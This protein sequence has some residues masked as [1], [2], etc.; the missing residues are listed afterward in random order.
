MSEEKHLK[1]SIELTGPPRS[2]K[3]YVRSRIQQLLDDLGFDHFETDIKKQ[4]LFEGRCE[5]LIAER[6]RSPAEV[7]A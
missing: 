5:T 4:K 1:V 6:R 3:T 7:V 2:G